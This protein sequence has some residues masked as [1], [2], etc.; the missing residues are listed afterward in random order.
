MPCATQPISFAADLVAAYEALAAPIAGR[1]I[2][3]IS[4]D[5]PNLADA[6]GNMLAGEL[7]AD[8]QLAAISAAPFG[9]AVVAFMN[10]GGVRSPGF[11]HRSSNAGEGDG[12]VT[13]GE[14]FTVQP[15]GNSLVTVT[16]T[17]KQLKDVLEQQFAGCLGQTTTRILIPSRGLKYTWNSAMTCGNRI[18]GLRL[19]DD[20][21]AVIEQ[22]LDASGVLSGPQKSYRVTINSFLATGGDGF[23]TF[24]AGTDPLGG[25]LDID[26]LARFLVAYKPPLSPYDPASA[27][28]L[29]PRVARINSI[30]L[31]SGR[32]FLAAGDARIVALDAR[33]GKVAWKRA[34]RRLQRRLQLGVPSENGI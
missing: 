19:V 22:I 24:A 31:H 33:T 9:G 23:T 29:R 27:A 30:A 6:A 10:P 8:A 13:Y 15:F 14:A 11:T 16:L 21:G 2:G 5:L 12:I 28:L 17:S 3:S 26:A 32:V 18:T 4:G 34:G 20:E 7:I 1:V 25:A